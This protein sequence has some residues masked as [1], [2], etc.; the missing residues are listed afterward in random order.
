MNTRSSSIA[1]WL[2]TG[3]IG[4][5]SCSL[6]LP[7]AR[8]AGEY[9]PVGNDSLYHARRILDAVGDPEG[10]Y[11]FD[12]KIHAPEGSLLVWPWGYDYAIAALVRLGLAA[13]VSADPMAILDWIPVIAVFASIGLLLVTARQLGLGN[14]PAT[15][16]T[17]CMGLAPTTQ[18]LHGPGVID[19]HYAEMIFLLAA[20]A[21]G[22]AWLRNPD[23]PRRAAALALT[24]GIAPAIH[25]GLF[26]LQIPI[27]ATVLSFWLQ[28]KRLPTKASLIC[29]A[30]LLASTIAIL[31]PSLPFRLGRFEFYTLSWFHLYVAC[32]T[33]LM[34]VLM[35]WL[36]PTRKNIVVLLLGAAAMVI[37]IAREA[38]L[39]QMFL[40]GANDH[41]QVI[42]E[43][44]SPAKTA[45]ALGSV[46]ITRIYSYL[47]FLA[48]LTFVL[49]LVQCWRER[50]SMR[51]LFWA[52]AVL[53][54]TLLSLQLRMHYFGDFA[55]YL[56]WFIV[57]QDFAAKRPQLRKKIFLGTSLA[58]LLL[59]ASALRYQLISPMPHSN[60][61]SF[62]N[63]RP[64][65]TTLSK[66]CAED[67][68]I[69]LADSTLGH[70]IRYY[71]DCSVIANNFLL[72]PQH[73]AKIDEAAHLLSLSAA[74]LAQQA[75]QVKYVLLRPWEMQRLASGRVG[76][77]FFYPGTQR[78]AADLLYAPAEAAPQ[79]YRLLH[80]ISFADLD[81]A[82]YARLYGVERSAPAQP[83]RS[84]N[85]K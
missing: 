9:I 38:A 16:A 40:A 20:L 56:P 51:L 79:G 27:L 74:E 4:V 30:L 82:A 58:V 2:I 14:W 19:H 34:L 31:I 42:G 75:P 68:G 15:L 50:A 59:Y 77:R 13:G 57:A 7:A 22:L 12:P 69:V 67:P 78:L 18:L 72:T 71:T 5:L 83:L 1:I 3:V 80:E 85:G 48:P 33:S 49:C 81:N 37:P 45:I 84:S 47:I 26:I 24:L 64:I 44:Q 41:L 65:F 21:T 66:A 63:L 52:T 23:S 62:K 70:Y 39:A 8:L 29:A 10:F 6:T 32:C 36:A 28:G 60:D 53:G 17:L 43:I 35:S 25:N 11:Q 54:L 55:L 46:Y 73:F 76:Y 61:L